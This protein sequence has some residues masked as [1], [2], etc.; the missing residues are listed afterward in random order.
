MRI[1][2]KRFGIIVGMII[3]SII[4]AAAHIVMGDNMGIQDSALL[5]VAGTSVGV[6][7]SAI[8]YHSNSIWPSVIVHGLWNLRS[9]FI[10]FGNKPGNEQLLTYVFSSN[11]KLLTGGNFGVESS[12]IAIVFYWIVILLAI[13]IR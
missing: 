3:P 2:E 6:M 1:V 13:Y 4:F 9:T 11:S 8:T 5:L 12:F 10:G 7:F